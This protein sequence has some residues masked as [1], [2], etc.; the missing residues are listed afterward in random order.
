V[1]FIYPDDAIYHST[2]NAKLTVGAS[3]AFDCILLLYF[4]LLLATSYGFHMI[5]HFQRVGIWSYG[6]M[7]FWRRTPANNEYNTRHLWMATKEH[8]RKFRQRQSKEGPTAGLIWSIDRDKS[9]EGR[10]WES[11][12]RH[13]NT[14]E[15]RPGRTQIRINIPQFC[16]FHQYKG[17][18]HLPSR[19]LSLPNVSCIVQSIDC[20][21]LHIRASHQGRDMFTSCALLNLAFSMML[22]G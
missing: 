10:G 9:N 4:F 13:S 19:T 5:L 16:R 6:V 15:R 21:C 3:F 2:T 12:W 18:T 11:Q 14:G 8:H 22:S 1:S 20:T 17:N 7:Q